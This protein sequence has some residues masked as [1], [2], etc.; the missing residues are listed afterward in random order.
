MSYL[1]KSMIVSWS[2][3]FTV[4]MLFLSGATVAQE[5]PPKPVSLFFNQNLSFGAFSPG[6]SGG[7]V[8]VNSNGVRFSTGTVILVSQGYLY[9]PSIFELEGNPGTIVHLLLG[10]DA[11]LVGSG[12]GT[13]NLHLGD[14]TPGDPIIVNVAPPGRIQIRIGGTLT[15]GGQAANPPGFYNGYFNIMIIQE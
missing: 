6:A 9:F 15:V 8:T 10:P 14:V 12:G 7:T 4:L 1:I 5:M 2:G 13:M 11:T 3:A